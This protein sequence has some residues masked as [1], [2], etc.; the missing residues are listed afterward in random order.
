MN[1]V[2]GHIRNRPNWYC[3]IW[4]E[5]HYQW[6]PNIRKT[7]PGVTMRPEIGMEEALDKRFETTTQTQG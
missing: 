2:G 6:T 7:L 3:P 5:M 1:G 4:P